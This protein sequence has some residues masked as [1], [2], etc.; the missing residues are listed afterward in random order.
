[1]DLFL[2]ILWGVIIGAGVYG[3]AKIA[4]PALRRLAERVVE[5]GNQIAQ[6][7]KVFVR[8]MAEFVIER[9]VESFVGPIPVLASKLLRGAV[10]LDEDSNAVDAR[11]E[12]FDSLGDIE[13][14]AI[15][16]AVQAQGQWY[17]TYAV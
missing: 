5:L 1:M 12:E 3:L 14:R 2:W 13:D 4:W 16:D 6:I 7:A 9:I 17:D 15:R 11:Y 8:V 10:A